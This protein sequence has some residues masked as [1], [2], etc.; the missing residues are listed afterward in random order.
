MQQGFSEDIF[1]PKKVRK[2]WKQI[3]IKSTLQQ[4]LTDLVF[5]FNWILENYPKDLKN[6]NVTNNLS[7]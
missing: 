1:P 5:Q 2:S 3:L 6:F 7:N 4:V